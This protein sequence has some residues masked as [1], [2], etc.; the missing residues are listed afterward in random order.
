MGKG[1]LTNIMN[2][3]A[4][5]YPTIEFTD[6][7]WLW[8]ASLLW[9]RVYRIVPR[10]YKPNDP[11]IVLSLMESGEIGIP[12]HPNDYA[13]SIAE[14]FSSR[15]NS[16]EWNA[17]ALSLEISNEYRRLHRD[18]V[19]VILR[20]MIITRGVG[21]PY[22]DWLHVPEDFAT[23]YMT[24]L[25]NAVAKRNHLQMLSDNT[26]AWTGATYFKYNGE[27][28]SIPQKDFTQQ[29]A[30]LVVRDYLPTDILSIKP[31]DILLFREKYRAER[32]RFLIAMKTWAKNLSE[33]DDARV[34][35]DLIEDMNK[36]INA[37]LKDFRGS[38]STLK[39]KSTTGI[40]SLTFPI[41][42]SVAALIGG[43]DLQ[44][45]TL[46]VGAGAAGLALGLVSGLTDLRRE[47]KKITK[48]CDYSYLME[49][50]REW[51]GISR[52]NNDY[53]NYLCRGMKE[54]IND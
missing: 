13:S 34:G 32:Q 15:V 36:D 31:K 35:R 4:L 6:Y 30:T 40:I 23:L 43:K 8:S 3:N 37:S 48:E 12:I 24:Y 19:D 9:D 21:R 53:N 14:E 17:S 16:G 39:T 20:D 2:N 18:K 51:K 11:S 25:A 29:L 33:C 7:L 26:S 52:H 44:T 46:L 1:G 42:T 50:E 47:K 27:I 22:G 10:G 5:Y 45:S 38:L 49:M 41:V 54:F 28:E